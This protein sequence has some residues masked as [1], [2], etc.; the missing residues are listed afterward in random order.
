MRVPGFGCI[1]HCG[2]S[3][4]ILELPSW[5]QQRGRCLWLSSA[6]MEDHR[7]L[8]NA[9]ASKVRKITLWRKIFKPWS[10]IR[11]RFMTCSHSPRHISQPL[12]SPHPILGPNGRPH[13][14]AWATR[15]L[16]KG[17][18]GL[19]PPV[20]LWHFIQPEIR[21]HFPTHVLLKPIAIYLI[22]LHTADLGDVSF[23]TWRMGSGHR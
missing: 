21:N 20:L 2:M 9:L 3:A 12:N 22:E 17:V 7:S 16:L 1:L 10:L 15:W 19:G 18:R 4:A 11:Q 13:P 8:T 6:L 14:H 5:S 23:C